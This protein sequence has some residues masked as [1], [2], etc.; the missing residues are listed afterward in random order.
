MP[1]ASSLDDHPNI[2]GASVLLCGREGATEGLGSDS[3]DVEAKLL[4]GWVEDGLRRRRVE[5]ELGPLCV[6]DA[7]EKER[8]GELPRRRV[9]ARSRLCVDGEGENER[10]GGA[11]ENAPEDGARGDAFERAVEGT[12]CKRGGAWDGP[13]SDVGDPRFEREDEGAGLGGEV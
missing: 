1:D 4:W 6:D 9:D 13:Q 10:V 2:R 11:G 7:G 8:E 12:E 3:D 5:G